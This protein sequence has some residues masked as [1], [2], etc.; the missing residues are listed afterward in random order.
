LIYNPHEALEVNLA[1][2]DRPYPA[3]AGEI[4]EI[5]GLIGCADDDAVPR[6]LL[7]VLVVGASECINAL[8]EELF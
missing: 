7:G 5:V 1:D 2:G 8:A 6:I 3:I 4:A